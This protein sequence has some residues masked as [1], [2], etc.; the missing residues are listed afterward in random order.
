MPI[1]IKCPKCQAALAVKDSLAGKKV[2]CPKCRNS[3]AIPAP[4]VAVT[5]SAP[6]PDLDIEAEALKTF[7]EETVKPVAAPRFVELECPFCVER[8]KLPADLAGKQPPCPNPECKRI[9]KVPALKEEKPKDWRQINTRLAGGLLKT[10]AVEP[11]GAWGT[12][13]LCESAPR[14]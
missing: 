4:K 5:K 1:R 3:L 2:S 8:V 14:P 6:E 13:Q 9:I 11:E 10:D 7:A 12:A